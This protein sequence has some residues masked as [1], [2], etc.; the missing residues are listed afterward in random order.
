MGIVVVEVVVLSWLL[1]AA[2]P[3]PGFE[4]A[5]VAAEASKEKLLLSRPK[6]TCTGLGADPDM[7]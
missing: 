5:A 7:T 3:A 6:G 4:E 2:V 1:S